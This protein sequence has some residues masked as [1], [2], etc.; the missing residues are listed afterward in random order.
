M[1]RAGLLIAGIFLVTGA[2]VAVANPAAASPGS[3]TDRPRGYHCHWYN[4]HGHWVDWYDGDHRRRYCHIHRH[5]GHG[6]GLGHGHGH[7]PGLIG[8]GVHIGIGGH[9]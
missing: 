3:G 4:G 2:G 9:P 8:I 5:R 6:H 7:G 1:R